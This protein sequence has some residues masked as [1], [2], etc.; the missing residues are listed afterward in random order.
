MDKLITALVKQVRQRPYSKF[1]V[2][3][4][5]AGTNDLVRQQMPGTMVAIEERTEL[6]EC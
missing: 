2:A 3:Y 4:G 5:A 1:S 6:Q